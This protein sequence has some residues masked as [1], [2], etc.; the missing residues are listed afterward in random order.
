MNRSSYC[1]H[2]VVSLQEQMAHLGY[3][4]YFSDQKQ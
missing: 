2:A 1:S 4:F 3:I